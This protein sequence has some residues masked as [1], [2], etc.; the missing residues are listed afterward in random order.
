MKYSVD[1]KKVISEYSKYLLIYKDPDKAIAYLLRDL[2]IDLKITNVDRTN[3]LVLSAFF[4]DV[5]EVINPYVGNIFSS[6]DVDFYKEGFMLR[7]MNDYDK[8]ENEVY[9]EEINVSFLGV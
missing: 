2:M 4:Q 9:R 6:F 1:D 3:R 5:F 7:L 8:I